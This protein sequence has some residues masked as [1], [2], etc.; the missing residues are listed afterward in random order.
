MSLIEAETTVRVQGDRYAAVDPF[1][2]AVSVVGLGPIGI[3]CIARHASDGF[4]VVG[5]DV[6]LEK[7]RAL[8]AGESSIITGV[9]AERLAG[10]VRQRRIEAT[11]NIVAAVIDTDVTLL[12]V[13]GSDMTFVRQASRAIGQ[14]LSIKSGY[15]VVV[16]CGF[17]DAP[18]IVETVAV[19][20]STAS[21]KK[22]GV[23]F[24]ICVVPEGSADEDAS[25]GGLIRASDSH[26]ARWVAPLFAS[27]LG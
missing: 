10:G 4:R 26:A 8:K 9:V 3:E 27:Q 20:C 18:G 7:V 13:S 23:D 14:A 2:H 15:H 24:G 17:V 12:P 6:S 11:Q 16:L 22:L 25:D 19:E 1:K 5:V 21:G